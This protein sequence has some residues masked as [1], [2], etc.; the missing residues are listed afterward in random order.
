MHSIVSPAGG[1]MNH[2]RWL[3]LLSVE[4]NSILPKQVHKKLD[5]IKT[6]VYNNHRT[7]FN[8]FEYE[9]L[10]RAELD[11]TIWVEHAILDVPKHVK[12]SK[13]LV[14]NIDPYDSLHMYAK[15]NPTL[16]TNSSKERF[17]F[18][19]EK[20]NS[21]NLE[22][23]IAENTLYINFKDMYKPILDKNF[24]ANVC[25]FLSISN[26]YET[27]KEVHSLWYHLHI[28]A[29]D[30]VRDFLKIMKPLEH[31]WKLPGS[32]R[33]VN[34]DRSRDGFKTVNEWVD[35]KNILTECYGENNA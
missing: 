15:I 4:Y 29:E 20:Y 13:V 22:N 10:F 23:S 5:F 16:N 26:E 8:W 12:Q 32:L 14:I 7:C 18:E 31:P 6:N 35:M 24:Y 3:L 30:T 28:K 33:R 19:I 27:A 9:F 25:E 21:I 17:L 34:V 2:L 11:N 1:G